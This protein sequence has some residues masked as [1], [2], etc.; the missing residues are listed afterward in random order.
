MA[1]ISGYAIQWNQPA[2]IGGLFEECF[3]KGAFNQSLIDN[4]DVVVLW[5]HDTTRPLARVSNRT[6]TLRSDKI[7]LWYS[8][9]PDEKSPMGQE[10]VVSVGSGLVNEVSVGFGSIEEQ[11]DDSGQLPKRLITRAWLG[12]IS[13]VLWGAYG[14]GTSAEVVRRASAASRAQAAMRARGIST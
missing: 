2:I 9:S 12:E 13:I 14:K 10:V 4:P 11:W 8:F 3:A 6:L 7:G 5:G 1:D